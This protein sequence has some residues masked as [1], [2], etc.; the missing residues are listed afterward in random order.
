MWT[1]HETS[2]EVEDKDWQLQ[3]GGSQGFKLARKQTNTK[4]ELKK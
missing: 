2:R 1:K 4:N 3:V